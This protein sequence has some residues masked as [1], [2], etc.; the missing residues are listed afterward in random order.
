MRV[1]ICVAIVLPYVAR[2]SG[3]C[4]PSVRIKLFS[5]FLFLF[6]IL[7]LPKK[8]TVPRSSCLERPPYAV[9]T[10]TSWGRLQIG[11]LRRI[12]WFRFVVLIVR[13]LYKTNH[14]PPKIF[15][16][17]KSGRIAT[18]NL[19]FLGLGWPWVGEFFG[20]IIIVTGTCFPTQQSLV[21]HKHRNILLREFVATAVLAFLFADFAS[22]LRPLMWTMWMW[23]DGWMMCLLCGVDVCV[24]I[25]CGFA[26]SVFE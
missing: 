16:V 24:L 23:M 2:R 1:C 17:G 7:T 11:C 20:F 9:P 12:C 13:F 5:F 6:P 25:E 18:F 15:A 8:G 26:E 22:L 21:N 19:F 14:K 3:C 4:G 10:H